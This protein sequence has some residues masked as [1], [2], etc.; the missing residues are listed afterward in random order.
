VHLDVCSLV[1]STICATAVVVVS[2]FVLGFGLRL[3]AHVR[4]LPFFTMKCCSVLPS[5]KKMEEDDFGDFVDAG[6]GV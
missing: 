6:S 3:Q 4:D 5:G 2:I 1:C